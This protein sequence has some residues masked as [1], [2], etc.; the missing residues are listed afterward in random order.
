MSSHE[1]NGLHIKLLGGF[2]LSYKGEQVTSVTSRRLQELIA[3]LVINRNET[4][5]RQYLSFLF[6]PEST[7][8]QALANLRNLLYKLRKNLPEAE[9]YLRID[10]TTLQWNLKSNCTFD[11]GEFENYLQKAQN[12]RE[13][14]QQIEYLRKAVTHY[15]GP[16]LPECY[17][18][19][20]EQPRQQLQWAYDDVLKDLINLLKDERKI[21][22][23]IQVAKKRVEF[24]DLNERAWRELLQLQIR[25]NN[26][27]GALKTYK[28]CAEVLRRELDVEPSKETKQIY[29]RLHNDSNTENSTR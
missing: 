13:P 12:C 26:H 8:K 14:D 25:H 27:S 4:I 7:E 2:R 19:W 23:A 22:E 18:E 16:L 17:K 6:W 10:F 29:Q 24:D 28:N 5:S 11:V 1:H 20:I 9:R 21:A 3:Y 15:E